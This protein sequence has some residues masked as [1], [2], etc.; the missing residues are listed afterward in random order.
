MANY[1]SIEE[2]DISILYKC[3]G[4]LWQ[5]NE[6]FLRKKKFSLSF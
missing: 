6:N 5:G 2:K 3:C 1:L 4:V